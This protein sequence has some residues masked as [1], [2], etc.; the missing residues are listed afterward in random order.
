MGIRPFDLFYSQALI[1]DLRLPENHDLSPKQASVLW[2][3]IQGVRSIPKQ[4]RMLGLTMEAVKNHRAALCIRINAKDIQDAVS[5]AV[6]GGDIIL[7]ETET[8]EYD[9]PVWE[10]KRLASRARAKARMQLRHDILKFIGDEFVYS[11]RRQYVSFDDIFKTFDND[12]HELKSILK[13]LDKRCWIEI[14]R[15]ENGIERYRPLA[16]P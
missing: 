7:S 14:L 6:R 12:V 3:A 10:I 4:A 15:D 1:G 2:L 5:Q 11:R 13:R 16:K 9:L 8:K